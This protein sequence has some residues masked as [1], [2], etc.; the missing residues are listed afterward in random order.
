MGDQS[1]FDVDV[2]LQITVLHLFYFVILR[3][4]NER[5][6]TSNNMPGDS[7]F[8]CPYP[9]LPTEETKRGLDSLCCRR[10]E[11]SLSQ[12]E[13]SRNIYLPLGNSAT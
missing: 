7:S 1:E 13:N 6:K 5:H 12:N 3:V 9:Y 4:G 8:E 2:N 11:A 10:Q